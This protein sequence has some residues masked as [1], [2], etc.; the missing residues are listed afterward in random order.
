MWSYKTA[1]P[2]RKGKGYQTCQECQR[3]CKHLQLWIEEVEGC[4]VAKGQWSWLSV[5]AVTTG[6]KQLAIKNCKKTRGKRFLGPE[7]RA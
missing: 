7:W 4:W 2:F 1:H 3:N 6:R 5:R